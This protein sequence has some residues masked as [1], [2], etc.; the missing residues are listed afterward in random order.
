MRRTFQPFNPLALILTILILCG[1]PDR[2]SAHIGGGRIDERNEKWSQKGNGKVFEGVVESTNT[3]EQQ[4]ERKTSDS[5]RHPYIPLLLSHNL[6]VSIFD[7]SCMI[8]LSDG[9][10][11]INEI[12]RVSSFERVVVAWLTYSIESQNGC[13]TTKGFKSQPPFSRRRPPEKKWSLG[14]C[15]WKD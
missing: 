13:P 11:R 15:F 6:Q 5:N 12:F 8:D 14:L 3:F 9:C 1:S 2:A 7:D 10:T 4:H